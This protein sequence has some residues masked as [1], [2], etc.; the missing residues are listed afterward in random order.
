MNQQKL[1]EDNINLVYF[2]INTYCPNAITDDD[3]IQSGMVGL[4]KAAETWDESKSVFSTYAIRCIRNEIYSEFNARKRHKGVFSLEHEIRYEDN[5]TTLAEVLVG[6]QDVNYVDVESVRRGLSPRE[7]EVF[8]LLCAGVNPT[9]IKDMFGWSRQRS[10][11][12]MRKIR[13]LWRKIYGDNQ[14]S[15]PR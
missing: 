9:D 2:T 6:D 13:L 12:I 1:I 11:M 15:L 3:I 7:K 4:C 14:D 5:V 10:N 8:D